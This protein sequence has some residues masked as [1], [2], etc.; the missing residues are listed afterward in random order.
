MISDV[1]QQYSLTAYLSPCNEQIQ[2][3]FSLRIFLAINQPSGNNGIA[4]TVNQLSLWF[5]IYIPG[6]EQTPAI[7][8]TYN[9]LFFS[10]IWA[11]WVE[12]REAQQGKL[13]GRLRI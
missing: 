9:D 13:D 1:K 10:F 2:L 8:A 12:E 3:R 5:G 11:V 7:R 4:S 6:I